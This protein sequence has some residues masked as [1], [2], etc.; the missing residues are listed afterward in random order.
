M[1]IRKTMSENQEE[2]PEKLYYDSLSVARRSS[3]KI[4]LVNTHDK[5]ALLTHLIKS[6]NLSKVI[7]IIKTKRE[8]DALGKC[9]IQN[10]ISALAIHSNKGVKESEEALASF[11]K[12]ETKVLIMTDM[13]L[14]AQEFS[15]INFM[16]SYSIPSEPA[17]Y[18][19]RIASLQEKGE[20]IAF[21]CEE[22]EHLMDAIQFA[23]K[24]EI[25]EEEP[26]GFTPSEAPELKEKPKKDKSKKPRHKKSKSK[27]KSKDSE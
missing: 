9:L 25:L 14:Q 10:D 19:E 17:Y 1:F 4:H 13:I 23:M 11:E 20:A 8:A 26:A 2:V 5:D 18:Y 27:K 16:I 6:N 12:D 22:E 24:V 21:V 3:Q 15:A 7:V